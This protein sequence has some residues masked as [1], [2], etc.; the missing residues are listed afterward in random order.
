MPK[1]IEAFPD[2]KLIIAG[3]VYGNKNIYIEQIQALGIDNN[4]ECYFR[5]PAIRNIIFFQSVL[6]LYSTL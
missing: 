5:Y 2:V 6:S 4:V 3:E 1:V